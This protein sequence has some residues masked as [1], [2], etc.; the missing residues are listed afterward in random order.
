MLFGVG[1][2]YMKQLCKLQVKFADYQIQQ[3]QFIS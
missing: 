2:H 3:Y 1:R